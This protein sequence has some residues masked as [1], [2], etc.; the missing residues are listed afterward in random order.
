MRVIELEDED[1]SNLLDLLDQKRLQVKKMIE[2][3]E[4]E[5]IEWR[6]ILL[7]NDLDNLLHLINQVTTARTLLE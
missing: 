7:T 5:G 6:V 4:E 3:A 2:G 1:H